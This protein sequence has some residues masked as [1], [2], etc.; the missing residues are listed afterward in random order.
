MTCDVR[1]TNARVAISRRV[2]ALPDTLVISGGGLRGVHGL[3]ALAHLKHAGT[4]REI[5]HIVGTS[6]GAILGAMFAT[7]QLRR[8]LGLVL[9]QKGGWD[10]KLHKLSKEFGIDSGKMLDDFLGALF[11]DF[12]GITFDELLDVS[13]IDL[14]VCATNLTQ[15]KPVY[16][17]AEGTPNMSVSLAIRHSC[18][19]P[20]IF[21]IKRE[22]PGEDVFVD[23]GITANFPIHHGR[24]I[25]RNGNVVGI[26]YLSS[27]CHRE[28]IND[29]RSFLT[30]IV[31]T[32]SNPC[33]TAVHETPGDILVFLRTGSSSL[34]FDADSHRRFGWFLDGASQAK[35]FLKKVE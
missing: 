16:F 30:S 21:A 19:L 7:D 1:P 22:S 9:R 13:G 12:P 35:K 27:T 8:G 2:A 5:K 20:A 18:T 4:L 32:W 28:P 11:E 26:G 25:S 10:L 33:D 23:G 34:D 6:S 15:R 3:G 14:H 17:C 24:H 31:E 29:I